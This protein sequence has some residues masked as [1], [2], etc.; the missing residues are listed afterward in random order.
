MPS[1]DLSLVRLRLTIPRLRDNTAF[2]MIELIA[3]NVEDAVQTR[4]EVLKRDLTAQ[5]QQLLR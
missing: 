3:L 1:I 4:T 5:F 2:G